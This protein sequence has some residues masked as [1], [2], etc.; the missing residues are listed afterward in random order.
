MGYKSSQKGPRAND[1]DEQSRLEPPVQRSTKV[2][3]VPVHRSDTHGS[4]NGYVEYDPGPDRQALSAR[5]GIEVAKGEA[6]KLQRLEREFG[7]ER[8]SRW[9]E[10]GMPIETM[11][12]PR[13]MQAFRKRQDE[14]REEVSAE[15]YVQPKLEVSSPD[16]P[17]EREAEAVVEMD[18]AQAGTT[19][20]DRSA[21]ADRR[22]RDVGLVRTVPVPRSVGGETIPHGREPTVREA[23]QGGGKPLPEATRSTT[24]PNLSN[25]ETI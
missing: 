7:R 14:S 16:D 24:D 4:G 13:D 19:E 1:S 21:G 18:E 2:G 25:G 5:Y 8:V 9:A 20:A 6:R 23:V 17:A 11:G 22:T 12:K 3:S 15:R 10:E